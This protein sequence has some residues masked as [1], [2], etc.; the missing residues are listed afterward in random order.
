MRVWDDTV[1]Y[2]MLLDAFNLSN[3][4]M[5]GLPREFINSCKAKTIVNTPVTNG[6][7]T[8]TTYI[9]K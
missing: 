2:Q 5:I 9:P 3:N 8:S 4:S 6:F 7:I 1:Q